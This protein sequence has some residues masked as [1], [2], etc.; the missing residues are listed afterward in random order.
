MVLGK[1]REAS[2][3]RVE[4]CEA[5]AAD[6]AGRGK[7]QTL[8]LIFETL[9]ELLLETEAA[10]VVSAAHEKKEYEQACHARNERNK[11]TVSL[12]KPLHID[13]YV[14]RDQLRRVVHQE[15]LLSWGELL[16]MFGHCFPSFAIS[17]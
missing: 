7:L 2:G 17:L 9:D 6:A 16:R 10:P 3:A 5:A 11:Q 14:G 12:T 8:E 1:K 4:F 13:K 15:V